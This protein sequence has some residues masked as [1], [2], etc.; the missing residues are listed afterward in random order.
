MN[1]SKTKSPFISLTLAEVN[2][3]ERA[4]FVVLIGNE[5]YAKDGEY[6][7]TATQA[8]KHYEILLANILH[9]ID[10]GTVK[11]KTAA[12][13]CLSRLHILPLRIH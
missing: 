12:M 1:M 5:F 3:A 7:F 6:T 11:Q 9:T 4:S 8:S 10:N 2:R 13:K